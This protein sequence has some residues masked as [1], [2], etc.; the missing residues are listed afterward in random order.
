MQNYAIFYFI[1]LIDALLCISYELR[2]RTVPRGLQLIV[3]GPGRLDLCLHIQ[4]GAQ[5][6]VTPSVWMQPTGSEARTGSTPTSV[7]FVFLSVLCTTL[8]PLLPGLIAALISRLSR[9]SLGFG[10]ALF[11]LISGLYLPLYAL[12]LL[13]VFGILTSFFV[14]AVLLLYG[15]FHGRSMHSASF[16]WIPCTLPA[17]CILT[18]S[19]FS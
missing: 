5:S 6:I 13:L 14:A 11:L 16:P 2:T 1:Y 15:R 17:L 3:L 12:L 9:E 19:F 8:L 10:D 18:F 7:A 4:E